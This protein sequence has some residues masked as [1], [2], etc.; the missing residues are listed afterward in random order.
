MDRKTLREEFFNLHSQRKREINDTS[1]VRMFDEMSIHHMIQCIR[2]K[3][4]FIPFKTSS[5]TC[6]DFC[7]N[8]CYEKSHL[9][10]IHDN[11]FEDLKVK[12]LK[13]N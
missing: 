5:D 7:S 13:I 8:K 1:F 9:K 6:P 10:G 2:C 4:I 12:L 3:N 11:C